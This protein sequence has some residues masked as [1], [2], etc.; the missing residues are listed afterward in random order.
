MFQVPTTS[1]DVNGVPSLQVAPFGSVTVMTA[2]TSGAN[3][4][5]GAVVGAVVGAAVA[6]A[7]VGADVAVG[8]AVAGGWVA[9]GAA[10]AQAFN[11]KVSN[12]V[13]LKRT[14]T[15]L[16]MRFFSFDKFGNQV[17]LTFACE[18]RI[19]LVQLI[20]SFNAGLDGSRR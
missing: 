16:D 8:A 13:K 20:T 19:F 6:G 15:F 5:S 14:E 9:T 18:K 10:G 17:E 4:S 11:T 7:S 12:T 1:L 3:V 2:L